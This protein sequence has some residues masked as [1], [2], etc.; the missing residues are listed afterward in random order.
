MTVAIIA[1]YQMSEIS[2]T[3]LS[4]VPPQYAPATGDQLMNLLIS[5]GFAKEKE[6]NLDRE[7]GCDCNCCQKRKS[8]YWINE[9]GAKKAA[10]EYVTKNLGL[11]GEKL[12]EYINIHFSEKWMAFDVLNVGEI[13]IE[14][15]ASLL[16]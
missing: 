3:T 16:K 2:G 12:D 15:M 6:D 4:A 7:C 8:Q 11:T 1:S 10:R 5:K 14:Q 9:A 13:E